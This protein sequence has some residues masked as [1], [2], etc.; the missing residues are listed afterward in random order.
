MSLDTRAVVSGSIIHLLSVHRGQCT[1]TDRPEA[2]DAIRGE[3]ATLTGDTISRN[4]VRPE[5]VTSLAKKISF[6]ISLLFL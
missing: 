4:V 1:A 6:H 3:L 5:S 2:V